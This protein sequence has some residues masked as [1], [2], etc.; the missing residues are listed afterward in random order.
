MGGSTRATRRASSVPRRGRLTPA[1]G[2][3]PLNPLLYLVL[4]A[5][6]APSPR[7][8]LQAAPSRTPRGGRA[9]G[10]RW[11]SPI[12]YWGHDRARPAY[13]RALLPRALAGSPVG[14]PSVLRARSAPSGSTA[15]GAGVLRPGVR[16]APRR[17]LAFAAG[18][19]CWRTTRPQDI[20]WDA[21][22]WF[23]PCSA[24]H[25]VRHSRRGRVRRC[26]RRCLRRRLPA[27]ESPRC[28]RRTCVTSPAFGFSPALGAGLV[29]A[30][31]AALAAALAAS[32]A[33]GGLLSCWATA[34]SLPGGCGARVADP[35]A[36]GTAAWCAASPPPIAAA[37]VAALTLAAVAAPVFRPRRSAVRR[38]RRAGAL[39]SGRRLLPS[40]TAIARATR[41]LS[42]PGGSRRDRFGAS[43]PSG[44]EVRARG[45]R[46][47]G[48]GSAR[49]DHACARA[50]RRASPTTRTRRA[51]RA[52][53][54]CCAQAARARARRGRA[55]VF[56]P[57]PRLR[58]CRRVLGRSPAGHRP[59]RL[60]RRSRPR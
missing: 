22:G 57:C 53:W 8:L 14:S 20:R 55:A 15:L 44:S 31:P 56:L 58:P 7:R 27:A 60:V 38:D 24:P 54:R 30:P 48:P 50:T 21:Q 12:H 18:R 23:R 3:A 33:R 26:K 59:P 29:R 43:D 1:T 4:L 52:S 51:L 11:S 16:P 10:F 2:D 47:A 42:P 5:V 9:V 39:A 37:R 45:G 19:R 28:C 49:D 41:P 34:T 35:T 17:D 32:R 36:V 13:Q 25:P 6:L 46:G 40:L